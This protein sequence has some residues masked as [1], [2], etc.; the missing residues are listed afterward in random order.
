M[1]ELEVR[2]AI[3]TL[4]RTSFYAFN[5]AV[6]ASKETILGVKVPALRAF[7]H[8]IA[9]DTD[10]SAWP[11]GESFELDLVHEEIVLAQEKN[12]R[13]RYQFVALFLAKTD[14][15]ALVDNLASQFKIKDLG[16]AYQMSQRFAHSPYPW[17]RRFA[18]SHL[19]TSTKSLSAEQLMA[20]IVLKEDP[21]VQKAEA[22]LLAEG[23]IYHD[24][25]LRNF[26]NHCPDKA[27]VNRTIQKAVESYR[28]SD[29]QKALL[30]Q[31]RS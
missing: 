13:K 11:V 30:R 21:N 28:I 14:G 24:E 12:E 31:L 22:W 23:L 29:T 20:L 3:T 17:V 1:N 25:T 18:Y 10:P 27:L 5:V 19:I 4:P 8:Q 16:L 2:N 9:K 26:L 15:W 6:N 7:A